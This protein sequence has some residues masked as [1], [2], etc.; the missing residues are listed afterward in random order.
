MIQKDVID[1]HEETIGW[2]FSV[3]KIPKKIIKCKKFPLNQWREF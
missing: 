3:K 2:L 1:L